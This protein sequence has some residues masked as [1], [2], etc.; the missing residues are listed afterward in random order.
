MSTWGRITK[1]TLTAIANAIRAKT[2][3]SALIE[4]VDMAAEING[5]EIGGDLDGVLDG[6]ISGVVTTNATRI[7]SYKLD[8]AIG[9]T[10][11]IAP[12]LTRIYNYGVRACT[13]LVE[14]SAPLCKTVSSNAFYNCT[15]LKNVDFAPTTVGETAFNR[16]G[17]LEA[18]DMSEC[19]SVGQA[20]FYQCES[21]TELNAPLVTNNMTSGYYGRWQEC[22]S[23]ETAKLNGISGIGNKDF[24][25][26]TALETLEA[27]V[28][29]EL[30]TSALQGCTSLRELDLPNVFQIYSNA[31]GGCT[32]L[33][34]VDLHRTAS[35]SIMANAF[36]GC[37]A[38]TALIIRSTTMYRLTNVNGLA[39]TAIAAGTGYIYVPASLV[40]TYKSATNWTTYASQFR[41]LEDYTDD[42]TPT[43]TFVP[44]AA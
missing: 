44:P 14:V 12:V 27:A 40:D 10:K 29:N 43:G 16:C 21:L 36:N 7:E 15:A 25:G 28:A 6:S 37:S 35:G 13:G 1:E 17:D 33:E 20:A 42:G 31:C 39:N 19:T 30:Y 9:I 26:C 8:G 41:A 3:K 32:A 38:L 11:L 2:G 22:T 23:L 24:Y 5:I 18:I 34:T 4:P